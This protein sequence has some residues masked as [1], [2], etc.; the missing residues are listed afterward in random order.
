MTEDNLFDKG[1]IARKLNQN[2]NASM[3]KKLKQTRLKEQMSLREA[4]YL[5]G[6]K[7]STIKNIEKG[8]RRFNIEAVSWLL[9]TYNTN[10]DSFL[11]N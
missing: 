1:E 7:L 4:A 8:E 6:F 2:F 5:S 10:I 9:A 11:Q 3:G